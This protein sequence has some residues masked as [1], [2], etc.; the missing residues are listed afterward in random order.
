MVPYDDVS[1]QWIDR[2]SGIPLYLQVKEL[3]L[4]RTESGELQP[5]SCTPTELEMSELLSVSRS[6]VRQAYQELEAEGVMYGSGRR[7]RSSPPRLHH[8][9]KKSHSNPSL[10]S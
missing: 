4:R 10:S 5:G 7:G 8:P 9:V 3:I 2:A 1:F 6:V